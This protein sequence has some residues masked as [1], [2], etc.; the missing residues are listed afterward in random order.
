MSFF[1]P[2]SSVAGDLTT[3]LT[4]FKASNGVIITA[5]YAVS[6]VAG[7]VENIADTG[8]PLLGVSS[9]T[10]T[11]T[12]TSTEVGIYCDPNMVYYND[13]DGSIINTDIGKVFRTT[14]S[15]V[16]DQSTG[17][18]NTA[19]AFV[20]IKRDPDGDADASKGLFKPYRTQLQSN[21]LDT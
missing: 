15:G 16:I 3:A 14:T 1:E 4:Y 12:S 5:G 19:Y 2:R 11:G 8:D 20:C 6:L 21:Q 9:E 13:A 10:V 17:A 18:I 7:F